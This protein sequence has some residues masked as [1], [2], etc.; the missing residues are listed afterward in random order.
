MSKTRLKPKKI[1]L[2]ITDNNGV[3]QECEIMSGL[4]IFARFKEY[5][6]W[7]GCFYDAIPENLIKS[8]Y[9]EPLEEAVYLINRKKNG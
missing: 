1:I 7:K 5:K 8:N 3:I 9:K 2:L 6:P 4:T